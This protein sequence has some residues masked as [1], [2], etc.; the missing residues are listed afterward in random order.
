MERERERK[1]EKLVGLRPRPLTYMRKDS[2]IQVVPMPHASV[3]LIFYP[4]P[5]TQE[6][7]TFVH[8]CCVC[9]H[10]LHVCDVTRVCVKHSMLVAV[11]NRRGS[12]ALGARTGGLKY[13]DG[14]N[15]YHPV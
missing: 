1:R 8:A 13:F 14:S 6:T 15:P 2:T 4:W 5:T 11:S 9:D 3:C 12:L 7:T 10:V